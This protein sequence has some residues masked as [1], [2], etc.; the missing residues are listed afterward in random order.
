MIE[1]K[2]GRIRTS[3]LKREWNLNPW[4]GNKDDNDNLL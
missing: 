4:L 3:T 1:K 2:E